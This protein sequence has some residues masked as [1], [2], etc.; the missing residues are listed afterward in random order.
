M[1]NF[2]K[3]KKILIT[4]HTGFKGAW[5]SQIL[6]EFGANVVGVALPAATNPSLFSVLGLEK[7]METHYHD[8]R[9]FSGLK[10]IFEKERP[11]IVFH[12]AAQAL[13]RDSYDDPLATFSSNVMGTANVLQAIKEVGG[14]KAAVIITTDKVYAN[15]ELPNPYRETDPLGGYD[16]YSSSKAAADIV[17]SSY[18]KSFFNVSDFGQKHN[19]LVAIARAGNVIGGGDW[20]NDRLVPDIVRAIYDRE[21]EVVLRSPRAVRP[22]QH[23]LDPLC[24]YMMLAQ[25]LYEKNTALVGAWNFG[26]SPDESI[27]VEELVKEAIKILGA[28][29][30]RVEADTA[31]HEAGLLTL[32]ISKAKVELKWEPQ[33]TF[34][35]SIK[36]TFDWYREY[37]ENRDKIVALTNKQ[38]GEYFGG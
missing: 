4:G 10:E 27:T 36:M 25:G 29:S 13:V 18:I 7:K 2:F 14:V 37:H 30:Y 35:Q 23:V 38:I 32:D 22:W 11:E 16:P 5:L 31:K 15:N 1:K 24:G 34:G 6:L 21:E 12:L 3:G 19:T 17:T 8:I 33:I 26:P 28:G 9:D 20:A